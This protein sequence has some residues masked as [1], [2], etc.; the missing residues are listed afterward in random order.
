MTS[1]FASSIEGEVAVLPLLGTFGL[2]PAWRFRSEKSFGSHHRGRFTK[3]NPTVFLVHLAL[4][5]RVCHGEVWATAGRTTWHRRASRKFV[6]PQAQIRFIPASIRRPSGVWTFNRI[7]TPP[8]ATLTPPAAP[9][10]TV[11]LGNPRGFSLNDPE[12]HVQALL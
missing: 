10:E 9:P 1:I 2:E 5:N 6:S 7:F 3:T 12:R 8:P 4:T 11:A